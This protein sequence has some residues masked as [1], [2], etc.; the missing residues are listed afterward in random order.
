MK[1]G[2]G[3]QDEGMVNE[4]REVVSEEVALQARKRALF[5]GAGWPGA[6]LEAIVQ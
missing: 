2:L 6:S 4:L 5:S 3:P 1:L